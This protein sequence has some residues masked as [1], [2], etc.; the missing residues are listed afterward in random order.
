MASAPESDRPP[1]SRFE[2]FV[3]IDWSG[4]RGARH[5]GIAV[6]SCASGRAAPVLVEPADGRFWSRQAVLD[7]LL[8]RAG[9]PMLVGFDFSFAA[10]FIDRGAHLPGLPATASARDLWRLVDTACADEDLGATSF[11]EAHRGQHFWLG[12]SD[13]A[14]ASFLRYRVCETPGGQAKPSTVFDALG[15]AQVAKASW[16]G[17]RLLHRLAGRVAIW[18]FDPLP[19][20]GA[21]VVEIYTAVAARAAGL[22]KGLSKLR[23]PEALAAALTRRLGSEV[24]PALAR[25]D[26][27][28]TDA[29]LAA[30]WLRA[31]ADR[32]DLWR[33]SAL[34]AAIAHTEGWTFGVA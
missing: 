7:W 19:N 10:P 6:A 14:K 4:A 34:T 15:A 11:V 1:L 2:R 13:G 23:T 27:H 22:R 9:E 26:D 25:W 5:R 8:A 16:A 24:P 17:M 30:A 28:A 29:V 18:P 33:P 31:S 32:A 21:A 12:A 20:A 3:A